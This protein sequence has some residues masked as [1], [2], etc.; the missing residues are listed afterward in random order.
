MH[1]NNKIIS[2]T[3]YIII[4]KYLITLL[5]KHIG[6]PRSPNMVDNR[7]KKDPILLVELTKKIITPIFKV[8]FLSN[9]DVKNERE[10][11]LILL[12][13]THS[14]SEYVKTSHRNFHSKG[15]KHR[16]PRLS[17]T[18]SYDLVT[19]CDKRS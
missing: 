15:S 17:C 6:I 10:T 13:L 4:I 5:F 2:I 11:L 3:K 8:S 19:H 18:D 12:A 9:V 7:H 1:N 16:H 14:R